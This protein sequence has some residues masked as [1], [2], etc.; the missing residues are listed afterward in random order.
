M[1]ATGAGVPGRMVG[2][3]VGANLDLL[4]GAMLGSVVGSGVAVFAHSV[5]LKSTQVKLFMSMKSAL[6]FIRE[7]SASAVL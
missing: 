3:G 5:A 7:K 4:E 1:A 2:S 6:V